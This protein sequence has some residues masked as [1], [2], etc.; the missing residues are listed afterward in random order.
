LNVPERE[1]KLGVKAYSLKLALQAQEIARQLCAWEVPGSEH[2]TALQHSG[3]A[4]S[5]AG[6]TEE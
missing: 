5:E 2:W 6:S 4:S 3:D 1:G